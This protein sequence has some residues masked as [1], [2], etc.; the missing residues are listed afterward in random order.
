MKPVP[1][2]GF[3]VHNKKVPVM[4]KLF[5]YKNRPMH[6]GPYP[7]ETLRRAK[8]A[9]GLKN[10]PAQSGLNFHRPKDP[11]SIINAMQD[12]QAMLDATREGLVKREQAEIP[13][14]LLERSNHLKSFGYYCDSAMV[15]ICEI[16]ADARLNVP[17]DNPDVARL[18]K[19]DVARLAKK[20]ETMQPKT[21]AA[22]IDLIMAGLR[23]NLRRP[24]GDCAHH[25]HALVF[26]YDL[27]RPAKNGEAGTDWI[28]NAEAQRSC[29]RAME[30]AVTLAN[31][32]RSLG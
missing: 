27:P 18:A 10:L 17:I 13:D 14:D 32:I 15:G 30:T 20:I 31:Y 12:Y 21:L 23:E 8:L 4:G 9:K 19:K 7:L 29:L 28:Q 25:S 24:V 5:S 6:L 3:D 16:P 1:C 2:H 26:L 11:L 22:G